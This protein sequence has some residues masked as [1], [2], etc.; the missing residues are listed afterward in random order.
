MKK[1]KIIMLG[2][3]SVMLM[4][5]VACGK[6]NTSE[7]TTATVENEIQ[8]V[9]ISFPAEALVE[10][11]DN[12][13]ELDFNDIVKC[14]GEIVTVME[15]KDMLLI[16]RRDDGSEYSHHLYLVD[17][18]TFEPIV[19]TDIP[20]GIYSVSGVHVDSSGRI[21][22]YNEM[23]YEIYFYGYT[24]ELRE[25]HTASLGDVKIYNAYIRDDGKFAY[26]FDTSR[27]GYYEYDL[28]NNKEKEI[29]TDVKENYP[30]DTDSYSVFGK[31][32]SVFGKG[33]YI[34]FSYLDKNFDIIYEVRG[35]EDGI[36]YYCDTNPLQGKEAGYDEYVFGY[37]E[38][39]STLE[40]LLY[41]T[42]HKGNTYGQ[43]LD[44][45]NEYGYA[46][47]DVDDKAVISS[48]V[49]DSMDNYSTTIFLNV[50]DTLSGKKTHETEFALEF[51]ED[52]WCSVPAKCYF[53]KYNCVAVL[54][55]GTNKIYVW[56]MDTESSVSEDTAYYYFKWDDK[57]EYE[58][59]VLAT[60][61]ERADD[62]AEENDV[63][64]HL[65]KDI[66]DFE[67]GTYGVRVC[68]DISLIDNALDVLEVVLERYPDGMLAQLDDDFGSEL[69]IYL[70]GSIYPL[71]EYGISEAVGLQNTLY[72][73]TWI[74]ADITHTYGLEQTLYH[75]I[76]HAIDEYM[77]NADGGGI[78]DYEW[79]AL[80]PDG[81]YYDYDYIAN[82]SNDDDRYTLY[83]DGSDVYFFDTYAKSY[84]H[85]DI[86]RVMEYAMIEYR[87]DSG[88][89]EYQGLNE[90]LR[91][92]SK[93][94]RE[95]FDTTGW[96]EE[97]EWE[98]EIK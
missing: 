34:L 92:L 2:I 39:G 26:Y 72:D 12:I 35:L 73:Y 66:E 20:D 91:Y 65:G 7:E 88:C 24:N 5:L 6:D 82:E 97:T 85:E 9:E 58:E 10:G 52:T 22:V 47:F 54:L 69:N 16:V 49:E 63:I 50:Y 13:Y 62:I 95:N 14:D 93:C 41:G 21:V 48:V 98:K 67:E 33:E 86:A 59:E 89:F 31:V 78:D 36:T 43:Y 60:L 76:M 38:E 19:E 55:D 68:D 94:I 61:R 32:E 3:M 30:E 17:P 77:D 8:E 96:P 11:T 57:E 18:I 87:E 1:N 70:S 75:E 25:L 90:K 29:L 23:N 80:N 51:S 28:V 4:F 40:M 15:Y 83:G 27:L 42:A 64:I 37:T 44:D 45:L 71:D 46:D 53:E 84:P 81:F 56:D 79:E 74:V